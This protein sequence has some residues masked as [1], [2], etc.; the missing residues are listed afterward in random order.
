MFCKFQQTIDCKC[1]AIQQ[2][3]FNK[4]LQINVSENRIISLCLPKLEIKGWYILYVFILISPN[5]IH[6]LYACALQLSSYSLYS[7]CLCSLD[8]YVLAQSLTVN[9]RKQQVFSKKVTVSKNSFA[10]LVLSVSV[11]SRVECADLYQLVLLGF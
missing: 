11:I 3:S 1:I 2:E 6:C 7:L 9:T 4:V 10:A 8:I 5:N